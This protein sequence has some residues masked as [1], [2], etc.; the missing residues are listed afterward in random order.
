MTDIDAILRRCT[1]P[2]EAAHLAA[3]LELLGPDSIY[4]DAE[5]HPENPLT[6][7][8]TCITHGLTDEQLEQAHVDSSLGLPMDPEVRRRIEGYAIACLAGEVYEATIIDRDRLWD[9]LPP[10]GSPEIEAHR[11]ARTAARKAALDAGAIELD[12]DDKQVDALLLRVSATDIEAFAWRSWLDQRTLALVHL[13]R[14]FQRI[15]EA[16]TAALHDAGRLN[17]SEITH[18]HWR[19]TQPLPIEPRPAPGTSGYY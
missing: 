5:I 12:N 2:H 17:R 10:D 13:N 6:A 11:S 8:H 16:L 4:G 7:G 9:G 15:A 19:V 3:A 1:A 18:I 14:R